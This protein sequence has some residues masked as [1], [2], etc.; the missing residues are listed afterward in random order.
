MVELARV[1]VGERLKE[2]HSLFTT[3][4]RFVNVQHVEA[5]TLGNGKASEFEDLF[6]VS[7]CRDI[8]AIYLESLKVRA[9]DEELLQWPLMQTVFVFEEFDLQFLETLEGVHEEPKLIEHR[10]DRLR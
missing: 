4:K 9:F 1:V 2:F 8:Q 10:V 6:T 7:S 3:G 5:A